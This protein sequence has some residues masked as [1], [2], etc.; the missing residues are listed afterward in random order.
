V[1]GVVLILLMFAMPGGVVG[2][3]RKI[4]SSWAARKHA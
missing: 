2:L 4:Q 1:Y 3:M